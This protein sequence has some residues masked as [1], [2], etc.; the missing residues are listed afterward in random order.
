VWDARLA[1]RQDRLA[2]ELADRAEVLENTRFVRQVA[3]EEAAVKPFGGL[4]LRGAESPRWIWPVRTPRREG[5]AR[6]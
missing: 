6:T 3:I 2:R 1:D 5:V 4:N